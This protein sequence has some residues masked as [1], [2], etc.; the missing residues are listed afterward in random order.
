MHLNLE[1]FSLTSFEVSS[2]RLSRFITKDTY[3]K[4]LESFAKNVYQRAL[5]Y[6]PVKTGLLKSSGV[7]YSSFGAY[8]ISF[9][10]P[11]AGY[12]HEIIDYQH[13]EQTSAKWLW[14]GMLDY[15]NELE[16]SLN[17]N[18]PDVLVSTKIT[19]EGYIHMSIRGNF[20]GEAN[21]K[22]SIWRLI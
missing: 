11:Y 9:E 21:H 22:D 18:I 10:T 5:T 7:L 12:V 6:I 15:I 3:D 1:V 16:I 14:L 20:T 13:A 19:P 4:F 17:D 2:V 8:T